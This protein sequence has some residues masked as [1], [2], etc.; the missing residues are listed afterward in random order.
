VAVLTGWALAVAGPVAGGT[1]IV[2]TGTAAFQNEVSV[3]QI[4]VAA[5]VNFIVQANPVVAVVKTSNPPVG[6]HGQRIEYLLKVTYPQ[7]GG[8]CGDDSPANAV[9]L[10]DTVPAGM[11]YVVNSTSVSIDNGA[12]YGLGTD[13]VD[14]TDVPGVAAVSFSSNQVRVTFTAPLTECTTGAAT[15]VVK[16]SVTVN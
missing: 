7:L 15:R 4:P 13:A 9:S 14:G 1:T 2:N 3:A 12:T 8:V 11:T 16:F 10:T 6:I 5:S